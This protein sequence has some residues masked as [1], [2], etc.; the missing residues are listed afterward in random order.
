MKEMLLTNSNSTYPE[1]AQLMVEHVE[2]NTEI[3]AYAL[4]VLQNWDGKHNL[5]N[6]VPPLYYS[7]VYQVLK[8]SMADEMDSLY[9]ENFLNSNLRL[10][11]FYKFIRSEKS[12]WWDDKNSDNVET[13]SDIFQIAFE[14]AVKQVAETLG[15]NPKEWSWNTVH[16]I[17]Y[18]H[19]IGK[20]KPFDKLFNV[21]PFE[22]ESGEEVL[23]KLPFK[24]SDSCYFAVNSGPAMRIAIDFANIEQAWSI[25]PTGQSG[26]PFS[27]FYKDQAEMYVNGKYRHMW[28][29][30]DSIENHIFARQTLKA[31]E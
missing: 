25:N 14:D 24:L 31:S 12:P 26:N 2:P 1:N 6:P 28:M 13:R 17:T 11:S 19:P 18:E 10:R 9:F 27:P 21:G 30:S 3:E 15:N 16:T 22:V 23:N 7:L 8:H 29:D 20:V 4:Q 5:E